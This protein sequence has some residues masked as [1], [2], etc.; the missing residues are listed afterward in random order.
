[1][2]KALDISVSQLR[3]LAFHTDAATRIHYVHFTVPKRSGGVRRLS[4]PHR[5]LSAAQQW[6]LHEVLN[7]LPV[8][9]PAQ[10]FVAGRS[11]VSNA[12]PHAGKAVLVNLDLEGFFP[13]ISWVRVRSVFQR[14]G[15][16]GQVATILALLCTECPR[17]PVSYAGKVYWVATGP[18][19]LPQG[20]CTSPALSNQVARRFDK[21]LGGL[22]RKFQLTYTRYAD[23]LSFSGDAT[24]NEMVGY[25]MARV[26]HLAEDEGFTVNEKKS[27]V[28]RPNAAQVVTGL[29]VNA[30]PSVPRA[31]LRRLRAIL[32]RAQAEG[33]DAQNRKGLPHFRAWLRGKIAFVNMVRPEIGAKMLAQLNALK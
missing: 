29:V 27:R 1:M 20:A 28:L 17:E 19:G 6:V 12:T 8:E 5:K 2:A 16:S 21:R 30:K 33:L 24:V 7:K 11:I 13:S 25:L 23:D 15:Y 14:L 9:P 18:R 31:E 3:W 26:R 32:H 10:G 4:A 22:A